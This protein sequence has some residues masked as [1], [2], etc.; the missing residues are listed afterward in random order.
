MSTLKLSA[1][2][3]GW[4]A[5]QDEQVW[6]LLQGLGYAG[7]EIA[8]T[9]VFPQEPY[10]CL[11]GAAL[12]AGVMRQ[13]YGFVIPSMQS[14]WFGQTGN[15]FN[16]KETQGLEEYTLAALEFANAC[17]C[18]NL[19]FGCP[20]NRNIPQGHTAAEAEGF[21]ERIGWLAAQKGA[22]IAL[23]AN[24]PIY[25]TNFLNTTAEAFALAEKLD[26]PGMG[27]NLDVGT[28]IANGERPGDFAAHMQR[29]SHVHISEP[30][31]A[32]IEARPL[33]KDLALLLHAVGYQG[34]VSVEMKATDPET[35]KRCLEY[36]AEVFA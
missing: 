20:R 32:P 28:M 4:A 5:E 12:F 9:R 25:N 15:I 14:I 19:V 7:L 31:L 30:G 2:N 17:R 22:V 34:F 18:R 21:F 29:V 33:H 11:P 26:S 27:V 10:R 1:S 16:Q 3:I 35:L 8:P 6:P 23:E 13:K 36:T 24:P